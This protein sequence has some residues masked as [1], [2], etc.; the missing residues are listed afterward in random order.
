MMNALAE[1]LPLELIMKLT[2]LTLAEIEN[3]NDEDFDD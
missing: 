1:K 2:D 3:L